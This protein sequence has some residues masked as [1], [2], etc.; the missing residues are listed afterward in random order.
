MKLCI[1]SGIEGVAGVV[2]PQQGQ[3]GNPKYERTRHLMT[4]EVN[5][6]VEGA[7]GGAAEVLA[8]GWDLLGADG[9]SLD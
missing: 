7:F 9:A 1:P 5:A 3:P 4:E 2:P 8:L 6:A